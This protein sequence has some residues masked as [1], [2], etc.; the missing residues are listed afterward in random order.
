MIDTQDINQATCYDV[1]LKFHKEGGLMSKQPMSMNSFAEKSRRSFETDIRV[2]HDK[3]QKSRLER[4]DLLINK[5]K[6]LTS[7]RVINIH[8]KAFDGRKSKRESGRR[9]EVMSRCF[10]PVCKK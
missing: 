5:K 2:S 7:R 8:V 1:N 4:M 3:N 6:R 9:H 10:K